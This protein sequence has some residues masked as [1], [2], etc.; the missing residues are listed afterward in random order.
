M[1]PVLVDLE[2]N[3][4]VPVW[5]TRV[6]RH[7]RYVRVYVVGASSVFVRPVNHVGEIIGQAFETDPHE[8]GCRI[9][10]SSL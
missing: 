7:G 9:V 5:S 3:A 2:S 6:T 8:I 1:R 4:L 10:S